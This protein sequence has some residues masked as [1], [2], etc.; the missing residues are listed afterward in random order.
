MYVIQKYKENYKN[1]LVEFITDILVE[2]FGFEEFR[3]RLKNEEFVD[4]KNRFNWIALNEVNEIIGTITLERKDNLEAFL[5][6]FYVKKEYRGTGVAK[7]LYNYFINFAK[8][9]QYK[10]IVLGTYENLNRAISF[11]TKNGFKEY[12]KETKNNKERH[13]YLELTS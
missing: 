7:E 4:N 12:I 8:D 2:E 5:K 3:E 10:K 1:Q 13:F 11:Y 9:E 6:K